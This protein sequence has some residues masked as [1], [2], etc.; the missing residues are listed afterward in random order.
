MM[1]ISHN[2]EFLLLCIFE[3]ILINFFYLI[4]VFYLNSNPILIH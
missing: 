3:E 4:G 1:Q 2:F